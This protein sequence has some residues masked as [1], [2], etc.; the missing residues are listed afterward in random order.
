MLSPQQPV[1]KELFPKNPSGEPP[2]QN[3]ARY[4]AER[5]K[6][7]GFAKE[8]IQFG[9][10]GQHQKQSTEQYNNFQKF[11]QDRMAP[12]HNENVYQTPLILKQS[13]KTEP[14]ESNNRRQYHQK[15]LGSTPLMSS[16]EKEA[17]DNAI[18]IGKMK[19]D[20]ILSQNQEM[21]ESQSTVGIGSTRDQLFKQKMPQR[22]NVLMEN[23]AHQ[24]QWI[25][26]QWEFDHHSSRVNSQISHYSVAK[27]KGGS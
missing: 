27:Q 14:Y 25:S 9:Q 17:M 26:G 12:M 15:F 18:Q 22:S 3:Y 7:A 1:K 20:Y 5:Q 8:S 11:V 16:T 10:N 23:G 24:I 19:N 4:Q 2:N 6:A 21:R 13:S